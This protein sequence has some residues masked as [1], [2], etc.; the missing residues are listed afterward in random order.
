MDKYRNLYENNLTK[1]SPFKD[2]GKFID[3]ESRKIYV[4]EKGKGK[5]IVFINGIAASVHTWKKVLDTLCTEFHVYGIDFIGTGFSEKPEIEYSIN[6]F[7]D[8]ILSLMEHFNMDSAV[9]VGNSL[10][11]EVALDFTAKYP[12]KVN[13]LVLIDSAGYQ[14]NKKIMSLLVKLSRFKI[15]ELILNKHITRKLVRLLID[16]AVFDERIIDK[17]MIDSYYKPMKT[18]GAVDAFIQLVKNLS[19]TEFNYDKAKNIDVETLIIWG[20]KDRWIKVSDGYRF[21]MDIKNSKLAVLKNCGHGPQEEKPR[22]VSKLISDFIKS[23]LNEYK[24][25][26][27]K[28]Y[29]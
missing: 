24:G 9:L 26:D 1:E 10:G 7:S 12:Q 19:Y 3:I 28:F 29:N 22:E 11:G 17:E 8:E 15:A 23:N 20:E 13:K 6:L 2:E 5:N 4:V 27:V 18:K 16:W 25:S 14:K 21:Y